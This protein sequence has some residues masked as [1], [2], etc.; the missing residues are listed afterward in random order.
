MTPSPNPME[1]KFNGKK[2]RTSLSKSLR[3]K[4][5]RKEDRKR[6]NKSR[7][8]HFS[9]SSHKFKSTATR[10]NKRKEANK[11][12]I[13]NANTKLLKISMNKFC[14]NHSS[15]TWASTKISDLE[16]T[17]FKKSRKRTKRKKS[18]RYRLF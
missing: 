15:I 2:A 5:K 10:K 12:R 9:T 7:K 14:Q 18:L 6:P 3:R 13:L 11:S 16:E 4:I 8:S 1:T 17:I